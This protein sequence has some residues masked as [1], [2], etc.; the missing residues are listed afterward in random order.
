MKRCPICNGEYP[1]DARFCPNDGGSLRTEGRADLVGQVIA[2]RYHIIRKLGEGGMGQVYLAE[3]VKM[4][5]RN[6]IKVMSAG[7]SADAEAV[8]RFNREAANAAQISHPNVCTIYDFGEHDGL[9]YLAMEY[10][11]GTTLTQI[12]ADHGPLPLARVAPIVVQV[13]DALAAA[14]DVGIVHRD[15]KP[16]NIMIVRH[17]GRDLVKVVDFGIAKAIGATQGT[18]KVTKTGLVVGTPEYM[19]PEQLVGDPID[20]HSDLYSLGLVTFRM[21][22]GE[23]PFSATSGQEALFKRLTE[24]PKSLEN[25]SP[26][27]HVPAGVQQALDKALQRNPLDRQT[28]PQEFAREFASA[29]ASV[30]APIE[31]ATRVVHEAAGR[32][33]AETTVPPTRIESAVAAPPGR[34]R[35]PTRSRGLLLPLSAAGAAAV[36]IGGVVIFTDL[37]DGKRQNPADTL[38][39]S[40]Q[41]PTTTSLPANSGGN[42]GA[43]TPN[44]NTANVVDTQPTRPPVRPPS[45]GRD[46]STGPVTTPMPVK[47]VSS[48]FENPATRADARRRAQ[49]IFYHTDAPKSL[50]AEMA[51]ELAIDAQSEFDVSGD[52][53]H[54]KRAVDWLDRAVKLEPTPSRKRSLQLLRQAVGTAAP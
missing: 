49:V 33:I 26:G 29:A 16:D 21:L 5:R 18:Q 17:R 35:H 53:D 2:E 47:P 31:A 30:T 10:V 3:H 27:L 37:F 6:A 36:V 12:L 44:A 52:R 41:L 14:H 19:S 11:E 8:S 42:T 46:S 45:N 48:E 39:Q 23:L 1:D 43:V 15:L 34:G 22:T 28:A 54:L 24:T 25:V 4:G 38:Q 9:I 7:V 51:E 40:T 32:N 50:R 13:A 20:G